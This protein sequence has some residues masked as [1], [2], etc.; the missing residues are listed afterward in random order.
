MVDEK[1]CCC[2]VD[3]VEGAVNVFI[4]QCIGF[5]G[6]D[7]ST[8]GVVNVEGNDVAQALSNIDGGTKVGEAE[9]CKGCTCCQ[10]TKGM[11][12]NLNETIDIGGLSILKHELSGGFGP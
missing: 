4:V 7:Q 2:S 9:G 11:I 6:G 3:G 10:N 12:A 8:K 1:T 5:N